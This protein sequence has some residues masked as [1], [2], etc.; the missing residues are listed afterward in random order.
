ML[1][2]LIQRVLQALAVMLV[3]SL[4]VFL[5]VFAVG[6]PIDVLISPDATQQIREETIRRY[7]FD[8][9]LMVGSITCTFL[10]LC[11]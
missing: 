8:P 7:G 1:A 10:G 3:I 9:P 6:N 4:L 5:G 2:F 11:R